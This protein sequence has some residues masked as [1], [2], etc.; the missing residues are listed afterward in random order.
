[1]RLTAGCRPTLH[2]H[3]VGRCQ[4]DFYSIVK[5]LVGNQPLRFYPYYN[6]YRPIVKK[7]LQKFFLVHKKFF[8]KISK[9]YSTFFIEKIP[10]NRIIIPWSIHTI[11]P[12][13]FSSGH[14]F[15]CPKPEHGVQ[16]QNLNY[17]TE[18]HV[19]NLNAHSET[20]SRLPN[21]TL[22]SGTECQLLNETFCSTLACKNHANQTCLTDQNNVILPKT[23]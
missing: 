10:I 15:F 4:A 22:N 8:L 14:C 1:M 3:L 6:N 12:I 11:Y 16:K 9:L 19:Q 23:D 5:E 13:H 2:R 7:K 18:R 21:E 17:R 20:E